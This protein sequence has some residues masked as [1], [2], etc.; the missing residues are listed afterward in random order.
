MVPSARCETTKINLMIYSH[1]LLCSGTEIP[2]LFEKSGRKITALDRTKFG[3]NDTFELSGDS[4]NRAFEKS[5]F[6]CIYFAPLFY[7]F[8]YFLQ[9]V[10]MIPILVSVLCPQTLGNIIQGLLIW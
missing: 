2:G 9:F 4:K 5:G 1:C 3:G 10:S 8:I 7:L 6:Y